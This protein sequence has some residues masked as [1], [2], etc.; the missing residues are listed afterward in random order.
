MTSKIIT[1]ICLF[2]SLSS[3]AEVAFTTASNDA[4][5]IK[6]K[7]GLTDLHSSYDIKRWTYTNEVEIDK[8]AR[9]P[10]SHP[11][12]TMNTSPKYLKDSSLLLATYLHEQFHW[13]IVK[14]RVGSFDDFTDDIKVNFPNVRAERPYGSGSESG[15]LSHIITC[16]L[17]FKAVSILL[18]AEQA[19]KILS[20]KGY[21]TWVY[22]TVL[23]P[24]NK[25]KLE[26][27]LTKYALQIGV[28]NS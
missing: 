20:S 15:T 14:N 18:G 12:L 1:V 5:E 11:I 4:D 2:F 9:T 27:L 10:H 3:F 26:A 25:A 21:Y 28:Q 17:E 7:D 13:H 19:K 6:I 22:Q 24:N 8:N 23:N 16:Y